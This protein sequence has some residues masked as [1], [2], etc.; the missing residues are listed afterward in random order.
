MLLQPARLPARLRDID[1]GAIV[2]Q[3]IG[4]PLDI[5]VR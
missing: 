2:E 1:G 3:N 5:L 4:V